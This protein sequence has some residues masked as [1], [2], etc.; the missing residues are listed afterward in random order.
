ME[1]DR[2]IR[3]TWKYCRLYG[4]KGS[5][6]TK[7]AVAGL[8]SGR[9]YPMSFRIMPRSNDKKFFDWRSPASQ[10]NLSQYVIFFIQRSKNRA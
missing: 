2:L 1:T 5:K 6:I 10:S 4:Q 9:N 7:I 3:M 8:E